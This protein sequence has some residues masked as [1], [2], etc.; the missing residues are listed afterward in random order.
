MPYKYKQ[1]VKTVLKEINQ[2]PRKLTIPLGVGI[3]F[4]II[5]TV[6]F[7]IER[8]VQFSYAGETCIRQISLFP[9]LSKPTNDADFRVETRDS[10]RIGNVA[11]VS[12]KTCFI[13]TKA[14]QEGVSKASVAPFG[15][16]LARKTFAVIVP[17]APLASTGSLSKP[18]PIGKP[19]TVSLSSPDTVHDY[20]LG[21]GQKST[22][23]SA[24]A[25]QIQCPLDNLA[26]EQGKEYRITLTRS[27]QR[28]TTGTLVSK[29]VS[30]LPATNIVKAGIAP[31]QTIYERPTSFEFEFDKE[32]TGASVS[33]VK[34]DG[35][36][37]TPVEQVA[38]FDKQKVTI[39]LAKEFDRSSS[40]ELVV[41]KLIARDGSTLVKPYTA[42]FKVSGGPK[43][44]GANVKASG[45]GLTQTVVLT[46]DQP[47]SDTQDITKFTT[48]K[49]VAATVT[50]KDNQVF[51]SYAGAPTCTDFTISFAKGLE[52]KY[53]IA[54]TET[55][56]FSSR[57]ICHTVET[58][59]YSREG[60]PIQAYFFG[61]GSQT[62]LFT[63]A[64]HGNEKS[65]KYAMD[66]W[67]NELE[68]MAKS[69]PADKQVVVIPVVN[70]DGFYKYGRKNANG[71][72]LN[73]NW[74][75]YNWS[76]DYET[77]PGVVE[78]GGGGPSPLSEP[79]T[80]ALA[81]FTQRLSPRFVATYHSQGRIVN[82]N[83]VGIA[84]GVGQRYAQMTGYQFVANDQT[85]ETF[86]TVVTGT[87]EDWLLE[88]G[89]AAILMELNTDTGNHFS[90]NKAAMWMVVN[91]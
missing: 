31:D 50:K 90:Q 72:N 30:T 63:G 91:S 56:A 19:L 34:L 23:C 4:A 13:A 80:Q 84:S 88:R 46:F 45:A 26:L 15:G 40:Y 27:F 86:G 20:S 24:K 3:L 79:E 57:T 66:S 85:T 21:V 54:Q 53:Q 64:I 41:D 69:I 87:Y 74:P 60:R 7:F 67:I 82:S 2:L 81:A 14:P 73:R 25:S 48:V 9:G 70:P 36:T 29:D 42:S 51:V 44:T 47:L 32:V 52:S 35:A 62:M 59:G 37:R 12:P 55:Q 68:A 8:P 77:S 22:T 78:H 43:L 61:N 1:R 58:I 49:G 18:I 38:R 6:A 75:T 10:F 17:K 83:D 16:L 71:V 5:Y 89:T 28:K 76:S 11:V 39:T 65:A 33:L